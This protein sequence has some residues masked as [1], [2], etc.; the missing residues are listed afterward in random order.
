MHNKSSIQLRTNK[1]RHKEKHKSFL[2]IPVMH[3]EGRILLFFSLFARGLVKRLGELVQEDD[4]A[5]VEDPESYPIG[6][7]EVSSP[8]IAPS[9]R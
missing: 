8:D 6:A 1:Q 3:F 4:V 7:P 5:G 9:S 2:N